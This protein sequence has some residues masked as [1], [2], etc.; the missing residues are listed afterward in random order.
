MRNIAFIGGFDKFDLIL[1]TAVIINNQNK[2]KCLIVDSTIQEKSRYIV[3]TMND[4]NYKEEKYITTFQ[5]VDIAVG[6]KTKMELEEFGILNT[7]TDENG[8]ITY[9]YDYVFIDLDEAR[10]LDS[11]NLNEKDLVFLTTAFDL[12]SLNKA[13]RVLDNTNCNVE[14]QK[15]LIGKKIS[16]NHVRYMEMVTGNRKINWGKYN[17]EFPYENGDWSIIQEN[18]R[19]NRFSVTKFSSKF[20]SGLSALVR[21]ITDTGFMEVNK[22]IR[23]MQKQEKR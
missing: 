2:A 14:I 15:I 22:T 9:S 18:Q 7:N 3:P 17:I 10:T 5:G 8:N 16:N 1:Y 4:I 21:L 20:K 19:E 6:F 12:Y 11:F 13:F 23:Q